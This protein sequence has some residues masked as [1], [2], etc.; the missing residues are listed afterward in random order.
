MLLR[1]FWLQPPS[2]P[3]EGC[4]EFHDFDAASSRSP[5]R[6]TCP[7]IATPCVLLV[8]L[9]QVRSSPAAKAVP[10]GCEPVR[11]SCRF[12]V[13]PRPL[14][15]SPFSFS[16]VCLVSLLSPCSSS[17]L[18]AMISPL[19]LRHGPAPMRSRALTAGR[20]SAVYVLR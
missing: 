15:I 3:R 18:L 9:W 2:G 20:P 14:T 4:A 16:A 19:A 7:T 5:L 17:R 11:M 1:S 6:S 10:S 13:S 8:Q 12:G